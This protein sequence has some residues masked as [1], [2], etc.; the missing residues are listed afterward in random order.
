MKQ[1]MVTGAETRSTSFAREFE[2]SGLLNS[3]ALV[4]LLLSLPIPLTC[5]ELGNWDPLLRFFEILGMLEISDAEHTANEVELRTLA[6][7]AVRAVITDFK[8]IAHSM[9]KVGWKMVHFIARM[10]M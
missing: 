2:R 3:A 1:W 5:A 8:R 10:G 4:I 9:K 7:V 6:G